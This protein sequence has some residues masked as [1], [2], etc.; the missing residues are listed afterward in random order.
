MSTKPIERGL[1]RGAGFYG[2]VSSRGDFVT[3]RLPREF[4]GPWDSWLQSAIAASHEQLTADWLDIYLTSPLWRFAISPAIC[5][6]SSWAGVMM[7]SVDK[8][9][10]YFPLTL[11]TAF[12][13]SR[14]L[15]YLFASA[16]DWFEA[17][18]ELAL[19]TLQDDF[20]LDRFDDELRA[21]EFP[22]KLSTVQQPP[23]KSTDGQNSRGGKIAFQIAIENNQ[24]MADAFVSLGSSLLRKL[25]SSYTFW[26]TVG[27][28]L[29]GTSL[30][31]CEGL[32]PIGAYAAM[33]N[34]HWQQQ[35]WDIQRDRILFES[36]VSENKKSPLTDGVAADSLPSEIQQKPKAT[37]ER[38]KLSFMSTGF[39]H[40]GKV[41]EINEDAFLNRPER[42]LW[43]VADGMG[44]HKGG[45]LA[46]RKI[47]EI[48]DEMPPQDSVTAAIKQVRERLQEV[49]RMLCR[50]SAE[51]LGGQIIGSTVVIL[52][53][54][55]KHYAF[56]WAGDS[57]LY[58]F[59][60]GK[61]LQLTRD[62]SITQSLI[63][64][65]G[66]SIS[67][68][69]DS[70]NNNVITRAVGAEEHLL[71][72]ID[73]QEAAENDK[74]LLCSDGL[75]KELAPIEIENILAENNYQECG[76][77]LIDAALERDAKDNITAIVVEYRKN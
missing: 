42:G 26:N 58:R 47:V 37:L 74:F 23:E 53:A 67:D 9:G 33:L 36:R 50:Y 8:V 15:P 6:S 39:S 10:R 49:N 55:D 70:S 46:S 60:D 65:D 24:N 56:M 66:F 40:V 3:R 21:I 41:R 61:L 73:K 16:T 2:K 14:L 20:D 43:V 31:V 52:I 13:D 11:A 75:T 63:G 35:A 28:E 57:R 62:H 1:A 22:L 7:P 44:G 27:S 18:E 72:D 71:L 59:R 45:Q 51:R 4:V 5:G 12:P 68:T 64:T 34:G 76:Q 32:P 19:T 25:L 17:L 69:L 77:S 29:V 48:L 38:P 30:L 54:L